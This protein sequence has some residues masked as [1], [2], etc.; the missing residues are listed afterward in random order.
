MDNVISEIIYTIIVPSGCTYKLSTI[1]LI[2]CTFIRY[3]QC[4]EIIYCSIMK[5]WFRKTS[6]YK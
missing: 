6:K 2:L 3:A 4:T 1:Q 5:Y